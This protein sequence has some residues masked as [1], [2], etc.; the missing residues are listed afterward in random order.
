MLRANM[1]V[2]NRNELSESKDFELFFQ[3]AILPKELQKVNPAL[4]GLTPGSPM[5]TI[6]P[7]CREVTE[8]EKEYIKMKYKLNKMNTRL[9]NDRKTIKMMLGKIST[10]KKVKV[11]TT[12]FQKQFR[13]GT[14]VYRFSKLGSAIYSGR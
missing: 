13:K 8:E 1:G 10:T 11:G 12:E 14:D 4:L 3:K 7:M 9:N 2:S 6:S 5:R